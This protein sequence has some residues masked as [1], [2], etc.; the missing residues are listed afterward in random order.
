MIILDAIFEAISAATLISANFYCTNIG[1]LPKLNNFN[2]CKF[3][4]LYKVKICKQNK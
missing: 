2:Y 4:V 3:L 1:Y